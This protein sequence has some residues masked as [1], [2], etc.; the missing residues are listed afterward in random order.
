MVKKVKKLEQL[1][2]GKEIFSLQDLEGIFG[3]CGQFLRALARS[4]R[5]KSYSVGRTY[6]VTRTEVER[7]Q[8]E[9][10]PSLSAEDYIFI[11][12]G[13]TLITGLKN[14]GTNAVG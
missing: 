3:R 8:R 6:A 9:G 13:R 10:M 2:K 11:R 1:E 5:M 4:G 7:L 12:K 14:G